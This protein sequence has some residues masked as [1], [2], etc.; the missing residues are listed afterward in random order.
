MNG[1]HLAGMEMLSGTVDAQLSLSEDGAGSKVLSNLNRGNQT[2]VIDG[3]SSVP[4]PMA[5]D[6]DSLGSLKE[7]LAV[8]GML[9][10][11]PS[12]PKEKQP[13]LLIHFLEGI[14]SELESTIGDLGNLNRDLGEEG[15]KNL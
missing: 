15:P 6:G 1:F 2:V 7:A 8:Y 12:S 10:S 5:K 4:D 14:S 13:K 3:S 11:S 9:E